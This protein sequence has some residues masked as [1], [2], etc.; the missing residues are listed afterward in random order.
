MIKTV[1][2][3][4]GRYKQGYIDPRQSTKYIQT[5]EPIIYRSS[6]EKAFIHWLENSPKVKR[7]G[8]EIIEIPYTFGGKVHRYYPDF[9]VEMDDS[10]IIIVEIKP[11]AQ[12]REPRNDYEAKEYVKNMHKWQAAKEF[13]EARGASFQIITEH[14]LN[15]L[16]R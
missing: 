7:W 2:P 1:K 5:G 16:V 15:K 12:T 6:Y 11:K 13:C 4:K 14:T 10:K 9:Y 8:S 3:K